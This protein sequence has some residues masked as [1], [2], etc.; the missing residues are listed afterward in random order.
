[1]SSHSLP[2]LIAYGLTVTTRLK[3]LEEWY[4]VFHLCTLEI[5]GRSLLLG[6]A[7]ALALSLTLSHIDH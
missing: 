6:L 5:S 1:M 7:L 4:L 2:I 3:A